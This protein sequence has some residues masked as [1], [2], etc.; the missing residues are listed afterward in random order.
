LCVFIVVEQRVE[1]VE[2]TDIQLAADAGRGDA[3]AFGIL[4]QRYCAGLIG[5]LAGLL[6]TREDA[7][8]LA[9]ET[10]LRAWREVPKLND[11][12]S[13]G[14]WLYRIAHNLAMSHARKPRPVPLADDPPDYVSDGV[15]EDRAIALLAAVGRLGESHREVIDRKYF[16]R[17]TVEEVAGQ[18]DIPAGTVR[19]RLSRAYIELRKMLTDES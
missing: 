16:G 12:A 2:K 15:D 11:P 4:V 5:Y 7:E 1:L 9:Q 19:S 6:N 17:A 10:F 18:L 14:G 13:F 8:E 3:N